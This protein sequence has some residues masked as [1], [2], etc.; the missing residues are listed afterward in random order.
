MPDIAEQGNNGKAEVSGHK[1]Q[2]FWAKNRLISGKN[3]QEKPFFLKEMEQ[4]LKELEENLD[5]LC[6][7][8]KETHK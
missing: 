4:D 2:W 3:H 5:V 6:G 8:L 1:I 7:N